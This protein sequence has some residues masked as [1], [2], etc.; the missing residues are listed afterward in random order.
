MS[1]A[2]NAQK[3]DNNVSTLIGVSSS[4]GTTPITVYVNPTTHRMLVTSDVNFA[5]E[6]TPTG[7]IDG[8]NTSFTLANTVDPVG[9]LILV[10]NGAVQKSGSGNDFTLS[11][12][13]ITYEVAPPTNSVLIAWYRY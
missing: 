10:L 6:E 7:T 12:T 3:D 13:T 9:S 8:S 2:G 4:D 11:G 5:D 1:A